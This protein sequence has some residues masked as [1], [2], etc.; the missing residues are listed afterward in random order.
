V[1]TEAVQIDARTAALMKVVP[2]EEFGSFPY[3]LNERERRLIDSASATDWGRARQWIA[4]ERLLIECEF[5]ALGELLAVA[6][7]RQGRV[8]VAARLL[9]AA[10]RASRWARLRRWVRRRRRAQT[11][12]EPIAAQA[13]G[14]GMTPEEFG[15]VVLALSALGWIEGTA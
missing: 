5:R 8:P 9:P 15:R 2:Y 1:N 7:A 13:A 6:R 4:S 3:V 14:V 11:G 12:A 10:P